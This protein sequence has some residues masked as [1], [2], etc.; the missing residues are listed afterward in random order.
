MKTLNNLSLPR[1]KEIHE[2]VMAIKK[3]NLKG[4]VD[5]VR[6]FENP[7]VNNMDFSFVVVPD[8]L[9]GKT[10]RTIV[11]EKN[12]AVFLSESLY[13]LGMKGNINAQHM[14]AH[15]L[16][17]LVLHSDRRNLAYTNNDSMEEEADYFARELLSRS[18]VLKNPLP[19]K[20]HAARVGVGYATKRFKD[21]SKTNR[22]R[23][24]A[25]KTAG[26]THKIKLGY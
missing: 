1:R 21:K 3:T 17:H 19:Q 22:G 20:S 15:E 18:K 24:R 23:V 16:G 10:T 4:Y 26:K 5:I 13:D 25:R 14:V 2:K 11:R 8:R 12:K 6:F 7:S 9:M